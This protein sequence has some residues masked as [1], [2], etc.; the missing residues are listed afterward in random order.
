[1][2]IHFVTEGS[3][4]EY[5]ER[6]KKQ[7]CDVLFFGFNGLGEVDY[8]RELAGE[9][10]K[11]ED[12]AIL[13]RESGC[14][15]LSGCVTD[16]CG[17][18]YQSAAV[19]QQGRI[20]GVSDRLHAF[21][22]EEFACGAHLKV[23]ETA[24]GKLGVCVGEDLFFPDVAA[25]LA[26]ADADVV[27]CP[28]GEAEDFAPQL[29]MRACAFSAGLDVCMCAAGIAQ[30]ASPDGGVRMRAARREC[31]CAFEICREY[32]IASVRTRGFARNRRNDF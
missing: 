9:T 24:A 31:D 23:Y 20:L 16:S 6:A 25:A 18:R 10:S 15:V 8:R 17:M 28:F 11:L 12:L 27:L 4:N 22:G 7:P 26:R 32:R 3:V 21:A 14:V 13:S 5:W 1:M 29:M 30:V 2:K 19:A